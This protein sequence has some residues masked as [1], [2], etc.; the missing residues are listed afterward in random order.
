MTFNRFR[1]SSL[2]QSVFLPS[3][4]STTCRFDELS[5]RQKCIEL[6]VLTFKRV[7][8]EARDWSNIVSSPAA[9]GLHDSHRPFGQPL[10]VVGSLWQ[11]LAASSAN[12][13]K[14]IVGGLYFEIS[15]S[16]ISKFFDRQ[17]RDETR[18]RRMITKLFLS[19]T[20]KF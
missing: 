14:N 5:S 6:V 19:L 7:Q 1:K 16:D 13:R 15:C 17:R 20:Q 9:S 8:V 10:A 4:T 3:V 18:R 12:N 2:R 11:S